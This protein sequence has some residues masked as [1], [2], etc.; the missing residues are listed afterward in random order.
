MAATDKRFLIEFIY[1]DCV[2]STVV[3]DDKDIEFFV[4]QKVAIAFMLLLIFPALTYFAITAPIWLH[5][6]FFPGIKSEIL[7]WIITFAILHLES[8][9]VA[10]LYRT[11]RNRY[12]VSRQRSRDVSAGR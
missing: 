12:G 3:E 6:Q 11:V 4:S 8:V 5:N 10:A 1:L 7:V 9:G 2:N